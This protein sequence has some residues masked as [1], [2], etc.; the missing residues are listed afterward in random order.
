M[1]QEIACRA[2]M[3]VMRPLTHS[4]GGVDKKRNGVARGR[5][6]RARR[7]QR[8]AMTLMEA[9]TDED[10]TIDLEEGGEPVRDD[11]LKNDFLDLVGPAVAR[12][13]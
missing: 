10:G 13:P 3:G 12:G 7:K 4:R 1:S 8:E 11:A 9:P 6:M 2:V 5:G